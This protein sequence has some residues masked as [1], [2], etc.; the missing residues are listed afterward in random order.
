MIKFDVR[1]DI[2]AVRKQFKD[3]EKQINLAASFA[4]NRAISS[5]RTV[6]TREISKRTGIKP[7]SAVRDRL[8]L[9]KAKP[10][11]LIAEIAAE[12]YTP[13]LIRFNARQ[14]K[15]GVSANA[16]GKRK[17]YKHTFIGNDGRT[18]FKRVGKARLPLKAVYGPRLAKSFVEREVTKAMD[19]VAATR[20]HTEFQ[21][22]VKRRTAP[23]I[24]E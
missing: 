8:H 2:N 12:R 15:G 3:K 24:A 10:T 4:L 6:A 21:R 18:V 11:F 7:Q 13:N 1:T 9:R 5:A 22:E 16:W 14:T 17:R 20:F 23:V 19:A